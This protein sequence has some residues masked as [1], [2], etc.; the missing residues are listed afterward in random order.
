M[1]HKKW[2]MKEDQREKTVKKWLMLK[3][4]T[5][6]ILLIPPVFPLK[7]KRF[8]GG[9]KRKSHDDLPFHYFPDVLKKRHNYQ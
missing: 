4:D 7:K 3:K 1:E 9:K 8:K 5:K 2:L 6:T